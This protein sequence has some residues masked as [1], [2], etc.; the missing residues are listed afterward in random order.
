MKTCIFWLRKRARK[1]KMVGLASADCS[2]LA[3]SDYSRMALAGDG[4][5]FVVDAPTAEH[6][7]R[8]IAA[9]LAGRRPD[10]GAPGMVSEIGDGRI[11]A[12]GV[13]ACQAIAGASESVRNW[14]ARINRDGRV[15]VADTKALGAR[16]DMIC[17]TRD[18]YFGK[19]LQPAKEPPPFR[20]HDHGDIV[21]LKK[22]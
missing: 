18:D 16:S 3:I 12:I 22:H 5:L 10:I 14:N 19:G 2:A 21:R 11:V 9:H 13:T 15:K 17:P 6:G 7:R 20:Y 1:P 4:R 8:R